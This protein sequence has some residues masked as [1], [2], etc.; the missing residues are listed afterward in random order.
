MRTPVKQMVSSIGSNS[1]AHLVRNGTESSHPL[2]HIHPKGK[3]SLSILIIPATDHLLR[4]NPCMQYLDIYTQRHLETPDSP[5]SNGPEIEGFNI[6]KVHTAGMKDSSLPLKVWILPNNK[7]PTGLSSSWP[8]VSMA[9]MYSCQS[10]VPANNR[11]RS[12]MVPS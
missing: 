1:T 12:L 5:S 3:A 11:T 6:L 10:Y 4:G 7:I 9:I 8:I 2:A